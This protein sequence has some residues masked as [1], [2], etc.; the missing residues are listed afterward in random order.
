[1][2]RNESP[3]YTFYATISYGEMRDYMPDVPVLLS[4]SSWAGHRWRTL[5]KRGWSELMVDAIPVPTIPPHVS[6]LAADCGGFVATRR[7]RRYLYT[8]PQLMDWYRGLGPHLAWAAMPDWCCE[9]EVAETAGIVRQRQRMTTLRAWQVWEH[10]RD[11][12]WV[13]VPTIQG[14]EPADYAWH[15]REMKPLIAEM[16][17]HYGS[18]F[19]VGI[20]TLC[21]RASPTMIRAVVQAV[22]GVLPDAIFH[23]WGV[24]L[25]LTQNR[26][27]LPPQVVSSDSATWH[28]YVTRYTTG[29]N[30]ANHREW[31]QSGLSKMQFGY[32]VALPRYREKIEAAL[33][34]PKQLPLA[35]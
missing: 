16:H 21:N 35:F 12:P 32:L 15:A 25:T 28:G 27:V 18:A 30:A 29:H 34:A 20:G 24:K 13:W 14:W 1:M 7:W 6:H 4:A 8:L 22:S 9:Q 10:H 17:H 5:R 3:R 19:R 26:V 11:E 23:L 31:R 2:T 33:A